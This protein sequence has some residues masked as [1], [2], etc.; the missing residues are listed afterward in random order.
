[1]R[2]IFAA[3][4]NGFLA[5][6]DPPLPADV[7][8]CKN[9]ACAVGQNEVGKVGMCPT[10]SARLSHCTYQVLGLGMALV[11]ATVAVYA[12]VGADLRP[13]PSKSHYTFNLRDASGLVGGVLGAGA[14]ALRER[15]G[16]VRL[17]AHEAARVFRDRLVDGDDRA[18]FD[19]TGRTQLWF[20]PPC[21][22][23]RFVHANLRSLFPSCAVTDAMKEFFAMEDAISPSQLLFSDIPDHHGDARVYREMR[24]AE[25]MASALQEH[26][27]DYN[28]SCPRTMEL[29]FFDDAIHHLARI[30]RVLRQPRGLH[31]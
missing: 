15:S 19:R 1:M 25:A 22:V 13:T 5:T 6:T 24:S 17:W 11:D 23:S 7:C 28:L 27:D 8:R 2:A 30:S 16:V 21:S 31:W 9:R 18:W 14:A 10:F 20:F 26:L 29:V 3:I 12:R 4:V